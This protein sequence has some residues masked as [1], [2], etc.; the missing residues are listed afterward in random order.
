MIGTVTVF[1]KDWKLF[2]SGV[3]VRAGRR[4]LLDIQRLYPATNRAR[5]SA[6][7]ERAVGLETL[8][9][10]KVIFIPKKLMSLLFTH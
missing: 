6:R 9:R 3:S 2:G 10:A 5:G 4:Y 1:Q 7:T 8:L